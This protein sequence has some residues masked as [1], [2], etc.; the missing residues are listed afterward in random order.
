MAENMNTRTNRKTTQ[1]LH[2]GGP[3]RDAQDRLLWRDKTC[4][5]CT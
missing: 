2:I 4:L 1:V 3:Y 5:A